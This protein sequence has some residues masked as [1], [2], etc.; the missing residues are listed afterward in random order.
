MKQLKKDPSNSYITKLINLL[1]ELKN[2]GAITQE[3]YYKVYP[4]ATEPPRSYGL[5][6]PPCPLRPIVA[7]RGSIMYGT[8]RWVADILAPMVGKTPHHLQNSADL[9]NTLS[10]IRVDED[11][12]LI[13][14]DVSALFTSVPVEESL[15]L[16]YEKLAADPSLA[17]RTAISPQQVTDLL[18][19]CLTTTYLKYDGSFYAQIEDAAMGSPVSPIVANLFMEDYE[20]KALEAYQDPPKYWGRYV[21]DGLAVI[22]TAYIEPFTQHLNAQHTSIQWTCELEADGKLPML[23]TLTTRMSDGSLKFSVYRKPTHTDQYLQFQSHQPME[24]KMGVIR[25]LTHRADTIISDP[26]DKEREIKHLMKVLSVA[27]Y[28]TWAWQAPGRNNPYIGGVTETISRLIRKTGVAAHAKPHT[29]IRSILVAPKDKVN[30]QYKCGVVYQLTCQDCKASNIGETERALKQRL[31]EHLK[32][33]S[34]VGYHMGY[35]KHKVDSQNIR[36]VDRDSRW[37]QRG[38][39]EAIH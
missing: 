32:D 15:T 8:A 9:V 18:R 36:I 34:P 23:D 28:S 35:N 1:K 16:I 24:H 5:H 27:G 20:G 12:S 22:K 6:K 13:S 25:T 10:Q 31:K 2:S 29:T 21:D 7:C 11:E 33:S 17:D 30:P 39:R 26:Q 3:Q 37:F 38:A 19:M 4:T 14:F